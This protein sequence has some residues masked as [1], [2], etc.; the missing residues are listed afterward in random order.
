[1]A[2]EEF[3]YFCLSEGREGGEKSFSSVDEVEFLCEQEN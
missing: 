1:M 2:G 3:R